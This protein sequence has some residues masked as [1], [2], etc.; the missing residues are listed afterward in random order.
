MEMTENHNPEQAIYCKTINNPVN[1][2]GILFYRGKEWGGA[3]IN[4]KSIGINWEFV[5]EWLFIG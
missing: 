4:Q 3:V 5:E 1:K 2:G